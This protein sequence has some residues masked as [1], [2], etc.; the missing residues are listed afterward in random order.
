M[1]SDL[2]NY[3]QNNPLPPLNVNTDM[4]MYGSD[5]ANIDFVALH[6]LP[7]DAPDSYARLDLDFGCQSNLCTRV[8]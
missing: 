8:D 5:K 6:Y 3:I 2:I 1:L 7:K 4:Q